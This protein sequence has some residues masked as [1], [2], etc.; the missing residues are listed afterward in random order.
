[1]HTYKWSRLISICLLSIGAAVSGLA[2]S[3]ETRIFLPGQP[4]SWYVYLEKTGKNNDPL[5]VFSFEQDVL[6]VSGQ[7]FGYIITTKKYE[8]FHLTLEFKWGEKKYP[9]R[10]NQKRDAGVLYL[11]DL[12]SGDKIWPRSIEFQIQEGDCGDFWM[13]DSTT[14]NFQG[15]KTMPERWHRELKFS[16]AEKP[17]GE[18]NLVEVIV[19]DGKIIHKLNGKIV[20]EGSEPSV[21][22]GNILLQ[23]EGAEIFYRNVT[24]GEL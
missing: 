9:P 19:R 14:I 7:D 17:H 2:Q 8:D 21:K 22:R 3:P 16:D 4:N 20:N 12:Y 1:M 18:W 15:K 6:H 11:I 13:T 5:K 24:V 23:S 10:E